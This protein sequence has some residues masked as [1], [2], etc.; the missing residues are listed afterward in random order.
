MALFEVN[1]TPPL[2]GRWREEPSSAQEKR[3]TP[4]L[5]VNRGSRLRP[6]GSLPTLGER[7]HS[8]MLDLVSWTVH[9]GGG[10]G[11]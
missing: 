1:L 6:Q 9:R 10:G 2:S 5:T 7:G 4:G 8:Q 11:M 3:P